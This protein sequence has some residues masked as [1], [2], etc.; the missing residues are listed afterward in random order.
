MVLLDVV[1]N[2]FGPEG[3]YLHSIAPEFFTDRHH[4]PM[5]RGDQHGRRARRAGARILY[6]QRAVLDRG[7][8]SRRA[9]ARRGARDPRRQPATPAAGTRRAGARRIPRPSNPPDPGER[10]KRGQPAGARRR[11][12]GRAGTRR[13]GTTMCI[14]FC[15][16]PPPARRRATTPITPAETDRLGRALAEGFAF[17]GEV[18]PYRGSAAR[19]AERRP[20]ADRLCRVRPEPRSGRQSRLRRAVGRDGIA[21]CGAGGRRGLPAAAA[22]PDAVHGRGMG[23]GTAVSVLLRFR[24]GTCR[25]RAQGPA[26]GIRPL[27]GVPGPGGAR[28]ASPIRPTR[29]RSS[30]PNSPGTTASARLMSSWLAHVSPASR[31]PARGRSCRFSLP[32][33]RAGA[34]GCSATERSP[35]A[36]RCP[37]V[38]WYWRQISRPS[39]DRLPAGSAD[40]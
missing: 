27:P 23:R 20:A 35:C 10:G 38:R 31:R 12:D 17:Q 24:L 13:N 3:G 14:T 18:M 39:P 25:R 32:S 4:T 9:A 34:S 33:S 5:G 11:A 29:R 37:G 30:R 28:D 22:D 26:R 36:G 2:H 15:T 7:V 6:P 21:R 40:E 19:R 16:S 1:Y 8:P